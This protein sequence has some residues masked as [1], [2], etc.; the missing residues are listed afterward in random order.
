M[1]LKVNKSMCKKCRVRCVLEVLKA[2]RIELL[3][4][5]GEKFCMRAVIGRIDLYQLYMASVK[6]LF[7]VLWIIK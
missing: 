5:F 6:H 3:K 2:R 4:C 1:E 7:A